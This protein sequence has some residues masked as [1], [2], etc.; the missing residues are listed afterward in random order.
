MLETIPSTSSCFQMKLFANWESDRS[1][2]STVQRVLV[3]SLNRLTL[4]SPSADLANSLVLTFKLR[5]GKRSLRTSDIPITL[6]QTQSEKVTVEMNVAVNIH[7]PH[8]LKKSNDLI[9]LIQ[10]RKKYG[11]RK[12]PGFKD[13][14]ISTINLRDVL[15][16]GFIKE[17]NFWLMNDYNKLDGPTNDNVA[18]FGIL[19]VTNCHSQAAVSEY[20]NKSGNKIDELHTLSEEED[21]QDSSREDVNDEVLRNSS[22]LSSH[23]RRTKH[24]R[25]LTSSKKM[26]QKNLKQKF[27]NL[28]NKLKRS[29]V[30][31]PDKEGS[32]VVAR[33]AQELED[34]FEELEN[35]SDSGPEFDTDRVSIISNPRPGLRP[36][37][38]S[39]NNVMDM[40]P[41]LEKLRSNASEE[42]NETD[43]QDSS[44]EFENGTDSLPETS[45]YRVVQKSSSLNS[46]HNSKF[47]PPSLKQHVTDHC[48][49]KSKDS[50]FRSSTLH[51][52]NQ[53]KLLNP[54]S[55]SLTFDS[56]S[57]NCSHQINT[58][59]K[60][61]IKGKRKIKI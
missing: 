25:P 19:S 23:N 43:E 14:A 60:S 61:F 17:V 6:Q 48:S 7:Y 4:F 18:P 10:R 46:A 3:L 28:M 20:N 50:I 55:S 11:K 57:S 1:S 33:T 34:W 59:Q 45:T 13:V 56:I 39:S 5:N 8:F 51:S 58:D 21:E 2:S 36:F 26:N 24:K 31:Q 35:L 15:Q 47:S 37:F 54:P 9:I 38:G 30:D 52:M 40:Y 22:Y 27:V 49:K 12:I 16:N 41:V 44:S 42:T 53:D 29:D 32:I